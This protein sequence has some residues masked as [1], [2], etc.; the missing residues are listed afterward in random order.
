MVGHSPMKSPPRLARWAGWMTAKI[1]GGDYGCA[2]RM[3]TLPGAPVGRRLAVR[4]MA[5][6]GHPINSGQSSRDRGS[7]GG[8]GGGP[9]RPPVLGCFHVGVVLPVRGAACAR[10]GSGWV[11]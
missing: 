5:R 8:G 6:F 9:P 10:P 11:G 1:F 4:G 7:G 2:N 3:R